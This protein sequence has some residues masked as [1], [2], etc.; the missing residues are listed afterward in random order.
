MWAKQLKFP[1]HQ[2]QNYFLRRG[3]AYLH[4]SIYI[5]HRLAKF[6]FVHC[7]NFS[8]NYLTVVFTRTFLAK[9]YHWTSVL[10]LSMHIFLVYFIYPVIRKLIVVINRFP[11]PII[12]YYYIYKLTC[13]TYTDCQYFKL[14]WTLSHSLHFFS[15]NLR[16]SYF[17]TNVINIAV[18]LYFYF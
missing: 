6:S 5:T 17:P 16:I 10:G 2:R 1:K 12:S 18:I 11:E 13:R 4:P 14:K 3:N 8:S 9:L 15:V 7:D